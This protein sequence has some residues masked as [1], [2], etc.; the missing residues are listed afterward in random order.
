MTGYVALLRGVNLAGR[1][2]VSMASLPPIFG[3]LGYREVATFIA[4]GNVLFAA[5]ALD[6]DAATTIESALEATIGRPI[7]V[8]LRSRDELGACVTHNPYPH[9][10]PKGPYVTFLADHPSARTVDRLT[11]ARQDPEEL[12][13]NGRDVYLHLPAGAGRSKLATA[14]AGLPDDPRATT[15]NWNTVTKLLDLCAKR[16]G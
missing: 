9:A 7:G 16:D 8:V 13:I 1:N 15:R 10:G 3:A 12:T 5:D 6:D 14:V 11:K 4:S 2:L